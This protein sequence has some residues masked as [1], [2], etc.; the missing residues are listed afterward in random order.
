MIELLPATGCTGEE[1]IDKIN[2]IIAAV[3]A[4]SNT[5]SYNDLTDKPSVNGVTLQ[6]AKTTGELMIEMAD[7]TDYDT[8]M[9]AIATKTEVQTAQAAAT[10]AATAAVQ[11]QI[12]GKLDK[13][14]SQATKADSMS[15]DGLLYVFD[16]NASKKVTLDA[17]TKNVALELT[18][19]KMVSGGSGKPLGL[20]LTVKP[21]DWQLDIDSGLYMASVPAPGLDKDTQAI[22]SAAPESIDEFEKTPYYLAKIADGNV[23]M[24]C[25]TVPSASVSVNILY[26]K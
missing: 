6:G 9:A 22:G 2:E 10:A 7:L 1:L 24:Q 18:S 19:Q 4:M 5:T 11:E 3:N 25:E 20:N 14:P 21:A 17:I 13:N 23:I 15:K 16:G 12:A 26:W 8:Q